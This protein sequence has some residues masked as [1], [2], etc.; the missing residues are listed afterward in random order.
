MN[1]EISIVTRGDD[2]AS[3]SSANRAIYEGMTKG[4]LKNTSIMMNCPHTKEAAELF[5][6]RKEFCIGLHANINAE[7]DDY[8]WP[9]VLPRS[10]VPD[11]YDDS[12]NLFGDNSLLHARKPDQEQIMAEVNAQLDLAT[13]MGFDIKYADTHMGFTWVVEG[14]SD[15]FRDWGLRKGLVV[16][17]PDVKHIRFERVP[18]SGE[19]TVQNLVAA[20]KTLDAGLY[21]LVGHPSCDDAETRKLYF[22]GV[23]GEMIAQERDADRLCFTHPDILK[24]YRD[25]GIRPTRYDEV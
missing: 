3:T 17:I 7:W 20:L 10:E 2:L 14:L 11:L 22:K 8:K 1:Q 5:A 6:G 4:V 12:G 13:S 19:A 21:L 16:G 15:A 25:R 23:T 9:S 24:V 18:D